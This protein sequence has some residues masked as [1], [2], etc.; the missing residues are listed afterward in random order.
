MF[1]ALLLIVEIVVLSV[2]HYFTPKALSL[3][4]SLDASFLIYDYCIYAVHYNKFV[5][6]IVDHSCIDSLSIFAGS[7]GNASMR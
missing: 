3:L 2:L 6:H 1:Y 5:S 7:S 4:L